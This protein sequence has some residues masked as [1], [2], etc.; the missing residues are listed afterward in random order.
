MYRSAKLYDSLYAETKD[1]DK[2]SRRLHELIEEC[3]KS[4]GSELL[5]VACGT[6]QHLFFLKNYYEVEGLDINPDFVAIAQ[7]KLPGSK[8]YEQNMMSFTVLKKFDVITCLFS[9]IGYTLTYDRLASTLLNMRNHLKPGGVL[10]IEPWYTPTTYK[11]GHFTATIQEVDGGKV[12]RTNHWSLENGHSK[13]DS[14]FLV[15][16]STGIE[17]IAE[18]HVLGL[19]AE[20]RY[21][22]ALNAAGLTVVFDEYGLIGRGLFIGTSPQAN[23]KDI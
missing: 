23:A 19:F 4:S 8:I 11:P 16:D 3:K 14:Q 18:T 17:H 6:G 10:I 12:V 13:G 20:E 5:D 9:S 21:K 22:E 2:E 1:Y 7:E 15:V